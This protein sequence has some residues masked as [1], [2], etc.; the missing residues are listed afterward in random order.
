[1]RWP[2][3]TIAAL[4]I[5]TALVWDVG[6]VTGRTTNIVIAGDSDACEASQL[7]GALQFEGGVPNGR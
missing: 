7:A 5:W 3:L 4:T 6:Y 1:M 2:A